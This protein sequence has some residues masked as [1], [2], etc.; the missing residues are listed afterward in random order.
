MIYFT[1]DYH[2]NHNKILHLCK[3]PFSD[4]DEMLDVIVNRHNAVVTDND[5]VY[6]LGDF[7]YKCSATKA[8]DFLRQL[9]GQRKIILGNHDKPLRSAIKAGMVNDLIESGKVEIIGST[10]PNI[11]TIYRTHVDNKDLTLSHYAISS[12]DG[13]YRGAWHLY[14][15]SHGKM[16]EMKKI[17]RFDVG[18]DSWNFHPVSWKMV[19][20]KMNL[21]EAMARQFMPDMYLENHSEDWRNALSEMNQAVLKKHNLI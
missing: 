5:I 11:K 6:D 4:M 17:C 7:A 15:H 14:G 8:V 1:S 2:T 20:D 13:V 3:R 19:E 9:N 10:D 21:I 18:V 16:P 12:W